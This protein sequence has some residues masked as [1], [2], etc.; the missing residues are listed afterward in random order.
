VKA[1][2]IDS[3]QSKQGVR[4]AE[5]P[6]P[7]VA[8]GEVLVRIQAA[9]VNPLDAQ[10]AEGRYKL[11][12]PYRMPLI[13]GNDLAGT[14]VRVGAG[15][16]A[17]QPGD[18]VYA[19]PDKARIGTF[20]ELFTLAQGDLA[21][22]PTNISMEEAAS[23]PLVSLTAW[24]ALVVRMKVQ[25]GQKVLIHAGS[26]GVGTMAIQLA[27]HLG[28]TV[29]TTASAA[30]ADFL[31][32]LGADIVIDYRT[33]DFEEALSG[34]DAVLDSQG[35]TSVQKSLRILK[36]GGMVVSIAGPPDPA[37]AEEIGGT[38]V[39]KVAAR[40]LSRQTRRAATRLGVHYSFMFMHAD[41]AQ[42]SQITALVEAGVLR[43]VVERVYPFADTPE[44]LAHL[45]KGR[46]RGKIVISMT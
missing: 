44:A 4:L 31:K 22:K 35:V 26:G 23:L 10:I 8:A 9:G 6:E 14:V 20:A 41:G 34:F 29:A 39:L 45:A 1:F 5:V 21:L 15:V 2:V 28:A 7:D 25:P 3:Y 30:N 42:L 12:L 11:F 32:E 43:P 13:L 46:T 37:F 36:P 18:E 17:F 24:Q 38:L 27:K 33:E 40:L 19:R 16:T